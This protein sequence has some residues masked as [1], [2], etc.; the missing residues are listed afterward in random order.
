MSKKVFLITVFIISLLLIGLM[1]LIADAGNNPVLNDFP[2][3]STQAETTKKNSI[4]VKDSLPTTIEISDQSKKEIIETYRKVSKE[5]LTFVSIINEGLLEKKYREYDFDAPELKEIKHIFFTP[6]G[7]KSAQ[8]KLFLQK[9]ETYE[10]AIADIY[11]VFPNI[12]RFENKIRI[13]RKGK[14]WLGYNF[15]NAEVLDVAM[16]LSQMEIAIKE[17]REV[18]I[19]EVLSN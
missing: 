8:G 6:S 16:L 17:K 10:N 13:N 14:D 5:L 3:K 1:M 11:T 15:L 18:V 7:E 19:N 12:N 4:P 9:I 2:P